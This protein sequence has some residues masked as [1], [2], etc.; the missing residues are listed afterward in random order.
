MVVVEELVI[1]DGW[2]SMRWRLEGAVAAK[3]D[4]VV[5]FDGLELPF[6][7]SASYDTPPSV[8]AVTPP[9]P[10]LYGRAGETRLVGDGQPISAKNAPTGITVEFLVSVVTEAGESIE[11]PIGSVVGP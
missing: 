10:P 8:G 1:G 7:L 5:N 6:S 2:G 4:V 11:I 3:V 9:L